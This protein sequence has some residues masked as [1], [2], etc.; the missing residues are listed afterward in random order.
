MADTILLF[1]TDVLVPLAWPIVAIA[2]VWAFKK[3][4]REALTRIVKAGPTGIEMSP[5]PSNTSDASL[6]T[7]GD[8]LKDA[9]TSAEAAE[10]WGNLQPWLSALEQSLGRTGHL[11]DISEIKRIAAANDRR[12]AAQ[13][14]MRTI[15][16]TQYEAILRMLHKPQSLS[17]LEDL[18]KQHQHKLEERAYP[19]PEA[20][21]GWLT[22]NGVAQITDGRYTLTEIGKSIVE[23]IMV[24]G[25][26]ARDNMG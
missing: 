22:Q 10:G 23:L 12:A 19:N 24:H 4:I 5:Q 13:F 26:S 18:F 16:G 20:W 1:L 21:L 11:N 17:D 6:L 3:E 2:G 15:F 8:N 7:K 25:L 9:A 14:L